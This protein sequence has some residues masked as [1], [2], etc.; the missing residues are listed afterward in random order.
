MNFGIII[1]KLNKSTLPDDI[2]IDLLYK[3]F[4]TVI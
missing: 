1:I 4:N 3:T 2:F